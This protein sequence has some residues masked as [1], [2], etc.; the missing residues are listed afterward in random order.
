MLLLD[1]RKSSRTGGSAVFPA[2]EVLSP[3]LFLPS[4]YQK[5][6]INVESGGKCGHFLTEWTCQ[7]TC[8]LS[9]CFLPCYTDNNST[10]SKS[11]SEPQRKYLE[12]STLVH[13][14]SSSS[15]A[16]G[17][18]ILVLCDPQLPWDRHTPEQLGAGSPHPRPHFRES[19]PKECPGSARHG[20]LLRGP[21]LR[22][23]TAHCVASPLPPSSCWSFSE[24]SGREGTQSHHLPRAECQCKMSLRVRPREEEQRNLEQ[25]LLNL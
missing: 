13:R 8:F 24:P 22:L 4:A 5:G 21:W 25:I 3:F 12:K 7:I 15:L 1:L 6:A 18:Q 20:C 10:S 16:F 14:C 9:L 19:Q 2:S 23:Q 17:H 11:K